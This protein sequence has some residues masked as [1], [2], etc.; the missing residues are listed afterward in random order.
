MDGTRKDYPEWGNKDLK[1]YAWYVHTDKWIL[2]INTVY[3]CCTPQAQRRQITRSD[4]VGRMVES[5]S[6]GEI[7]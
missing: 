1:G 2:S 3:P 7:K 4:N 5:F 6:E